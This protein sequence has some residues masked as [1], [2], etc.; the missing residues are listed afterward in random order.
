MTPRPVP[1]GGLPNEN[2]ADIKTEVFILPAADAME[3]EGS[4]V[5][6]G[7][8]IQW[9]PKVAEA[10]GEALPD[11]Q[12]FNLVALKLKELYG[13]EPGPFAEPILHLAWDY[14]KDLDI[15]KVAKELNGTAL[16]EIKDPEGKVLAKKDEV[17]KTF[18]VLQADGTTACGT[19]IFARLLR[20]RR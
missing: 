12:V 2:P 5:T 14:G 8:L 11:H 7:R 19:W 1:S 15:E 17:L 18:G 13:A 10:P 16:A 9:R 6:S 20:P 4:I 3:K